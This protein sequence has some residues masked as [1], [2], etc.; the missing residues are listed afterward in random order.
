MKLTI[1]ALATAL[2][3]T[4]AAAMTGPSAFDDPRSVALGAS[5]IQTTLGTQRSVDAGSQLT[6]REQALNGADKVNVY[7]LDNGD[8]EV[9]TNAA[10]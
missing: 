7:V 8:V 2:L 3:A 6:A 4:G 1:A 10:F 9:D 5:N